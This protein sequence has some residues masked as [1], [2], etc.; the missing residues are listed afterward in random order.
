MSQEEALRL[1]GYGSTSELARW[2]VASG[3]GGPTLIGQLNRGE[4]EPE[5]RNSSQ[6]Q[7]TIISV[8]IKIARDALE[9]AGKSS[10]E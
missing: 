7:G 5:Y 6:Y 10:A 4:W 3:Y 9:E 1:I 8:L 2:V